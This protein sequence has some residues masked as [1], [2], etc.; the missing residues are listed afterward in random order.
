MTPPALMPEMALFLDFDGTLVEIAPTP[1]GVTVPDHLLPALE[2]AR[3]TLG[4][5]LAVVSGRALRDIDHFLTPL[6]IAGSGSHGVERRRPDGTVLDPDPGI[7]HAAREISEAVRAAVGAHDGVIVEDK[8]WSASLHYRGAPELEAQCHAAMRKAVE[9]HPGWELVAGKMVV[10]G[11]KAG[12]SKADAVRAFM[13]ESPFA[14]RTPVFIGDDRT[15]EDGMRAAQNLGGIGIKVGAG[16]S[17][18]RYRLAGPA[19]VLRYLDP[20]G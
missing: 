10:E 19:D 13:A 20:A 3:D 1:D 18:A 9:A 7:Q 17:V 14:G 5:A 15:D 16:D 11:R 2:A 12:I 8:P 6:T 4:G